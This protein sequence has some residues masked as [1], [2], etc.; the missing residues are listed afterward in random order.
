MPLN[1]RQPTLSDWSRRLTVWLALSNTRW[2]TLVA[3]CST[4]AER[5]RVQHSVPK[6]LSSWQFRPYLYNQT[7]I[8]QVTTKIMSLLIKSLVEG[9]W[10]NRFFFFP[11]PPR[12]HP[13]CSKSLALF[14]LRNGQSCYSDQSERA[15]QEE[16]NVMK[17]LLSII[18]EHLHLCLILWYSSFKSYLVGYLYCIRDAQKRVFHPGL[19]IFAIFPLL[20]IKLYKILY[21]DQNDS[22]LMFRY[23]WL[24]LTHWI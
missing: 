13:A 16:Q 5:R 17:S 6:S 12:A 24:S 1:F 2:H 18:F 21:F 23:I 8:R 10:F 19:Y 14:G 11:P 3:T 22:S 7:S 20:I 15:R 9:V 4:G